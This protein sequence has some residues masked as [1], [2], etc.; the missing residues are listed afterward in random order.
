MNGKVSDRPVEMGSLLL[1]MRLPATLGRWAVT[2]SLLGSI[3]EA[4]TQ[5]FSLFTLM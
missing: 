2:R 1:E 5:M 4:M 3:S